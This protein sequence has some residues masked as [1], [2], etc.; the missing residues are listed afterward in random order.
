MGL[1][2]SAGLVQSLAAGCRLRLCRWSIG[3]GRLISREFGEIGFVWFFVVE[4]LSGVEKS[5]DA[6][7]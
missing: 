5:L 7:H 6:A 2:R 4:A 1:T 3:T